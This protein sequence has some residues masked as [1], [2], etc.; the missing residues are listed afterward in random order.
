VGLV[1]LYA[2]SSHD[3]VALHH[4][5]RRLD[6]SNLRNPRKLIYLVLRGLAVGIMLA[7]T[8]L[9]IGP[10]AGLDVVFAA[11]FAGGVM[12]GLLGTFIIG[13]TSTRTRYVTPANH[14]GRPSLAFSSSGSRVGSPA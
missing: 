5:P 14:S 6:L 13:L 12:G 11:A 1:L 9:A 8:A 2:I 3:R 7:L 10:A 4:I